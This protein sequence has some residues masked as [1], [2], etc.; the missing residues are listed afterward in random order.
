[1]ALVAP[2]SKYKKK[3]FLIWMGLCV[4]L[5][6]WFTYDGYFNEKF[7]SKHTTADGQPNPTLTLNRKSPPFLVGVAILMAG[8]LFV[9]RNKK[10]VADET[11]LVID[12]KI[13]IAYDSIQK[14]D[15][16]NF[17]SK[18]VFVVTYRGADGKESD[19]RI[20]YKNYDNLPV[21]LDHLVAKIS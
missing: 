12:D 20:S 17:D 14:I 2:L 21:I 13:N 15:K 11:G 6:A 10:V 1:M 18:G 5:A 19:L 3:T 7:I 8:Y 9:I 16:T 4:I